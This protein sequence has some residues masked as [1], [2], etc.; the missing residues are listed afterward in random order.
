MRYLDV[1]QV[2]ELLKV[3]KTNAYAIIRKLN[4][5]LESRGY[6]TIRGKIPEAYLRERFYSGGA[7]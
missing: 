3:G 1:E 6:M 4:R 2:M 5:E 7:V